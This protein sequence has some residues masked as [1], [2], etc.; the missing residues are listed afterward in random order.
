MKDQLN[1]DV[2]LYE[3]KTI[4]EIDEELARLGIDASRTVRVVSAIVQAKLAEWR[5]SG[6]LPKPDEVN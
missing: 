3:A 6:L 1:A 5:A 4:E 2:A